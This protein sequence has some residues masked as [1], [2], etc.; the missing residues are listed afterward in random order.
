MKLKILVAGLSLAFASQAQIKFEKVQIDD[1]YVSESA[2]PADIDKD[3]LLDIVAGDVWYKAPNWERKEIRPL[4]RYYPVVTVPTLPKGS[5][6]RYYANSIANFVMDID[7]DGWP[8]VITMN[9]QGAPAYW[10]KNP[11]GNFD[12]LWEEYLAIEL[13]HNESPQMMDLFGTGKEVLVAGNHEGDN[14][15]SLSWFSI[16]DDPKKIWNRHMI[17]NP[18]DFPIVG[19]QPRQMRLAAGGFGHGL[20]MADMNKDRKNDVLTSKGW[21]EQQETSNGEPQ[22]KFH[23]FP[24]DSLAD[25]QGRSSVFSHVHAADFDNDGDMDILGSSAHRYGL[26]W[27]E[28]TAPNQFKK[29]TVSMDYS[30]LHS[31]T[32]VDLNKD[33]KV[34]YVMGKRY[35]AH[36]GNDP[37]EFDP[38]VI[39]YVSPSKDKDGKVKFDIHII[40]DDSASGTQITTADFNKDGKIDIL[41]SNKKGTRIFYQ[42]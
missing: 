33:G 42:K 7:N 28:Q 38:A 14:N 24:F 8:D 15:Y 13:F 40:D 17:G 20:G 39:L 9:S 41:T 5:G 6:A 23:A 34:E 18:S 19:R 32:A 11:G 4:G 27:F 1:T 25:A 21:Y 30:Q 3:G 10:Y 26:W 31:V 16:P 22:W 2:V 29:H 35:L 36:L 12:Q 37:G